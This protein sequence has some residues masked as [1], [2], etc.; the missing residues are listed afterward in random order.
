[1]EKAVKKS[2]L[3]SEFIKFVTV[4]FLGVIVLSVVVIIGC[5]TLRESLLLPNSDKVY[6]NWAKAGSESSPQKPN[7]GFSMLTLADP[8]AVNPFYTEEHT[9]NDGENRCFVL[10][11]SKLDE[12][13]V[14]LSI[15][16]V[17]NSPEAL[18]PNN[19]ILYH[20][21]GVSMVLLPVV[22]AL[23]GVLICG[24][25]FYE[26]KLKRP[27]E[28]LFEATEK[29]AAQDL[30]FSVDYRSEDEL[31]TLCSYFEQMRKALQENNEKMWEMLAERRQLQ[32]SVAHDLRNPIAIIEGHTEYLK[33]NISKDSKEGL[34][35]EKTVPVLDNISSAAKRLEH[36]TDSI[37][38]IN[39]IEELDIKRE[40]V[41]FDNVFEEVEEDFGVIPKQRGIAVKCT[42]AVGRHRLNLDKQALFRILENLVGNAVRYAEKEIDILFVYDKGNLVVTVSDDG[43]GFSD[44][45]IKD[46]KKNF[47]IR[48]S[49]GEHSGIGLTVCGILARKHG[50]EVL[51]GNREK[52]AFVK[53]VLNVT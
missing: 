2:R 41:D 17:Y 27:I 28:T 21:C 15:T 49:D 37:R 30:D 33:M 48:K 25:S 4:T 13:D 52:G 43:C 14:V 20:V 40:W 31:G 18:S 19:Q 11:R 51:C 1:M 36:Y 5:Y 10:S 26:K 46:Q 34:S 29:I 9:E 7:Y 16:R 44:S 47:V 24:F 38:T 45:F 50:G 6:L 53:I 22:F 32:A 8:D 39:C 12:G 3:R 35:A 23:A 42:N